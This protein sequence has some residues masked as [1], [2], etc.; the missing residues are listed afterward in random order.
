MA[1]TLTADDLAKLSIEERVQLLE[2]IMQSIAA[3]TATQP[4]PEWQREVVRQRLRRM[5][6]RPHP[7][8]PADEALAN[9]GKRK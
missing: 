1:V 5:D 3:D 9:L 6:E 2:L 7:G 4:A 8:I